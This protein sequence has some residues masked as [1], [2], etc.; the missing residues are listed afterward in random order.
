MQ[1]SGVAFGTSGTRG[2]VTQMTNEVCEAYTSAFL[3]V[4]A[5]SFN[6]ERVALGIDLRPNSPAIAAVCARRIS[7]T[8]P[9][10]DFDSKPPIVTD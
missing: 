1:K 4:V 3:K 6:F 2:L 7:H 10:T 5:R 8:K 9:A